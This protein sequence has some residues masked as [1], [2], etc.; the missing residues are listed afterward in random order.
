MIV[1]CE[2]CSAKY[3]INASKLPPGGGNIK[4]PSCKSVFFVKPEEEQPAPSGGGLPGLP[5]MPGGPSF[6]DNDGS[7]IVGTAP[8]ALLGGIGGAPGSPF[9]AGGLPGLPSLPESSQGAMDDG[10]TMVGASPFLFQQA[11]AAQSGGPKWKL[12]T[13]F[14]LV[15]DFHDDAALK[16]WMEGRDTLAGFKLSANNGGT[17]SDLESFP[18]ILSPDIRAKLDA[19]PSEPAAPAGPAVSPAA[20]P[21]GGPAAAPAGP[22]LSPSPGPSLGGPRPTPRPSPP[23][24]TPRPVRRPPQRRP[25]GSSGDSEDSKGWIGIVV[26]LLAIVGVVIGLQAAGVIDLR[27]KAVDMK[28]KAKTEQ[29]EA[30]NKALGIDENAA[31]AAEDDGTGTE[32]VEEDPGQEAGGAE[33]AGQ[34]AA[35]SPFSHSGHVDSLLQQAQQDMTRGDYKKA[36]NTLN[37]AKGLAP[38]NPEIY[39]LLERAHRRAGNSAEARAAAEQRRALQ[40]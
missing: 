34:P 26:A 20:P 27:G 33:A 14:G 38:N 29:I 30:R 6:D 23:R 1:V 13:N 18:E 28:Q 21:A 17:F 4:C 12:K 15:F 40:Q 7:T 19:A 36:I 22:S 32:Y 16:S 9:D 35:P 10:A 3:R 39:A 11:A 8:S 37:S 5:S 2:H 31:A 24:P 25:S